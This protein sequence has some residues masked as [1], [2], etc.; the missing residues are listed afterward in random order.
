M[1]EEDI[2]FKAY[3]DAAKGAARELL[4]ENSLNLVANGEK[5]AQENHD[6][7]KGAEGKK[8]MLNML[9]EFSHKPRF[10]H[11]HYCCK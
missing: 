4:E 9:R 6:Y 3:V 11:I 10:L 1:T 5:I 2:R 7:L 8:D